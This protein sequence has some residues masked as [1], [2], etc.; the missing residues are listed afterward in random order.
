RLCSAPER[1]IFDQ[2][3]AP[4]RCV[5]EFLL[6]ALHV[7]AFPALGLDR[8]G[9]DR[10][11]ADAVVDAAPAK[12]ARESGERNIRRRAASVAPLRLVLAGGEDVENDLGRLA[13]H[14]L[15]HRARQVDVAEHFQVPG[16]APARLVDLENVADGDG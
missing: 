8:A 10:D 11:D 2:P 14:A 3:L 12:R 4:A 16:L 7:D 5:A 13:A 9:T 15:V 1:L 6:G